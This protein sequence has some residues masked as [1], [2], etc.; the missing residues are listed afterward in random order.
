MTDYEKYEED[1]VYTDLVNLLEETK[2]T[3]SLY[4]RI[5]NSLDPYVPG[6]EL[7]RGEIPYAVVRPENS[8]EVSIV[9]KYANEKTIPVYV[10]GSGTSLHG[11]ARFKEKGIVINV[12]NMNHL[13]IE[14]EFG[15]VEFG[16]GH[17]V[18]YVKEALEK[19]GYF[20]PLV[21]GSIRIASIGGII[22]N[23]TS[24]HGVDTELG[25]PRD[26]I[27]G[28]EVVL[29]TGEIVKTGTKSLRR[30]AGTDLTQYFV[31]GDGLMGVITS[32][33]MQLMPMFESTYGVAYFKDLESLARAVQRIYLDKVP[34]P[35]FLEM[36][37][38]RVAKIAF[39]IKGLS[40]P[41]GPLIMFQ[42]K[43]RDKE[44]A[45]KKV[46]QLVECIKKE[47]PI[48]AKEITDMEEWHKIWGARESSLPYICQGGKGVFA[49][50]EVV[51]TVP[52]LVACM[53]DVKGMSKGKPTLEKLGEPYLFGHIGCLTFHPCF[54]IPADWPEE[55]K[56]K[57]Y[58]EVFDKEAELNLKYDTAGGEWGQFAM[59]G[60]FFGAKWGESA[61]DFVEKI[62]TAVDPKNILNP[63]V[64]RKTVLE[65]R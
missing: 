35:M 61:Y 21:P 50:C 9:M 41:K 44:D 54:I 48:E 1:V 5:N 18:L 6:N 28:L 33:R 3:K 43:G 32:I 38:E 64:M 27:L 14:E 62:K 56:R 59:R 15:W 37:D 49:F 22:S 55:D 53:Q 23:N 11:A 29:P 45:N 51:S 24:A 31:G 47:S 36:L 17:R 19:R 16:P 65:N 12:R 4:E 7:Q 39:K 34:P 58:E 60:P 40:E 42:V 8:E 46:T 2:V 26:Y 25:K 13:K 10:R 20:L 57:A 30:I 52:G 63:N